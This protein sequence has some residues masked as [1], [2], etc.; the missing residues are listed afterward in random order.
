MCTAPWIGTATA[1]IL[2]IFFSLLLG[3]PWPQ[4]S[5][6]FSKTILQLSV[7]GLG[8]SLGLGE[9]IRTG[10]NSV[11]YTIVGIGCTLTMGHVIGKLFKT[12]KNTLALISVEPPF[13]VEAPLPPWRRF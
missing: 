6:H 4:K 2:G 7:V 11:V 5:A 3:N 10:K 1:L 12:D 13:V 9:V 8:S